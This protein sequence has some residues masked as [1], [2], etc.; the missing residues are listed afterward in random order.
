MNTQQIIKSV[1]WGDG[2][3]KKKNKRKTNKNWEPHLSQV[4]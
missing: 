3:S 1:K 2:F 4:K